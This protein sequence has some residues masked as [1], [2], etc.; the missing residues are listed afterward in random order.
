MHDQEIDGYI[1]DNQFR[2]RDPRFK[3]AQRH[4]PV[5]PSD[6]Q[7]K[8]TIQDFDYDPGKGTCTCPAGHTM[9]PK[10]RNNR[11]GQDI[12]VKFQAYQHD[13]KDCPLKARCLRTPKQSTARQ[14]AFRRKSG[15]RTRQQQLIEQMKDKI[16]SIR[17]RAIYSQRLGTVEPVFGNITHAIGFKRFSLRGKKKVTGQWQL[18]AMIHNIFKVHRMAWNGA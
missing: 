18:I 4:K 10:G 1:A 5:D 14:V 7:S 15:P 6:G 11:I 9:W 2:K 12:Y 8:F 16:D 17:G 13:C 3:T